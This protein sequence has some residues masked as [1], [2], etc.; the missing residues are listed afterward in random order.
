MGPIQTLS[1]DNREEDM[2]CGEFALIRSFR[3]FIPVSSSPMSR[4]LK[5][6]FLRRGHSMRR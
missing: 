4:S 3:Y 2:Y 1:L 5:D 6:V